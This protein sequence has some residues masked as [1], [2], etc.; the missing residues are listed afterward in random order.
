MGLA[1]GPVGG[2]AHAHS[3]IL[4]ANAGSDVPELSNES[5]GAW[6]TSTQPIVVERSIDSDANGINRTA[7]T[8]ATA[9]RLP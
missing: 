3:Y 2:T 8:N 1:D 9:T 4:L 7:G 6:I 5:L